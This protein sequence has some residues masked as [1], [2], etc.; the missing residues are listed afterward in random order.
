V[1]DYE[2]HTPF[3]ILADD[4][5]GFVY[6]GTFHD[7][8]TARLIDLSETVLSRSNIRRG[9]R[10]KL[11]FAMVEA[12]QNIVRHR[13][14]VPFYQE[15]PR[16]RPAFIVRSNERVQSL[17]A[18]NAVPNTVRDQILARVEHINSL[19]Q[20]ALKRSFLRGLESNAISDKGGA[21]LGLIEMARRSRNKL[22]CKMIPL[23]ADH[24][25]YFLAVVIGDAKEGEQEHLISTAQRLHEI[26]Y[27]DDM[28]LLHKGQL[29]ASSVSAILPMVQRDMD[30][31]PH[32]ASIRSR[33]Y[34]AGIEVFR[35]RHAIGDGIFCLCRSDENYVISIGQEL[36]AGSA[37][38]LQRAVKEVNALSKEQLDVS[39]RRAL[40]SQEPADKEHRGLLD[41]AICS[42]NDLESALELLEDRTFCSIRAVV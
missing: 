33:A 19:D 28:I 35:T 12:Y 36:A 3:A 32:K 31:S 15:H 6:S 40:L 10:N 2:L 39:F 1:V 38:D 17:V 11:A 14:S 23:G 29:R 37:E 8:L 41:L 25:V 22:G 16:S 27:Q 13:L 26:C 7:S 9:Q 42:T 4:D 24:S 5:L 18:I 34:L 21:G 30:D 20:D